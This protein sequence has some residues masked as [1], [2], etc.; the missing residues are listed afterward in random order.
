MNER[1]RGP[2]SPLARYA[3]GYSD[4]RRGAINDLRFRLILIALMV[5]WIWWHGVPTNG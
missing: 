2:A 4:D 3:Y 5:A 1:D